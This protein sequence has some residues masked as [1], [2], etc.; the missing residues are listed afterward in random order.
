MSAVCG[1]CGEPRWECE[2]PDGDDSTRDMIDQSVAKVVEELFDELTAAPVPTTLEWRSTEDGRVRVGGRG[3]AGGSAVRQ[4][5]LRDATEPT[6]LPPTPL[7][8]DLRAGVGMAEVHQDVVARCTACGVL[9]PD[10][11]ETP[12]GIAPKGEFQ[13]TCSTDLGG[14]GRETMLE[15]VTDDDWR[16]LKW[17]LQCPE[18]DYTTLS[19]E[20]GIEPPVETCPKCETRETLKEQ[21]HDA[22]D[23]PHRSGHWQYKVSV[24]P[25]DDEEDVHEVVTETVAIT[26]PLLVVDGKTLEGGYTDLDREAGA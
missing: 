17:R 7:D 21:R 8:P 3:G 18:C 11:F 26:R 23:I 5:H 14:C 15:V 25:D 6:T 4:Q 9:Q 20:A 10:A 1:V 19:W 12:M 22:D 2:C 13:S 24:R 16:V